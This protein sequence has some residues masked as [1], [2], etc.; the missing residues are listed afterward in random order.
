ML[1]VVCAADIF[2][3]V[4]F[5]SAGSPLHASV[6]LAPSF[7]FIAMVSRLLIT[8]SHS[9]LFFL[10]YLCSGKIA[11]Y[12]KFLVRTSGFRL[13][14]RP[15]KIDF[16]VLVTRFK[17]I[18]GIGKSFYFSLTLLSEFISVKSGISNDYITQILD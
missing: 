7:R 4:Y 11:I 18:R 8:Y 13:K 12:A 9:S 16:L 3:H 10:K 15:T 1:A 14:L 17:Q 5:H 6:I 2:Y